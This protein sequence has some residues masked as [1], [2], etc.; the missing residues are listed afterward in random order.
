MPRRGWR[1]RDDERGAVLD[2][3]RCHLW[4]RSRQR[5]PNP[6]R[7]TAGRDARLDGPPDGCRDQLACALCLGL[8][9]ARSGGPEMIA[10]TQRRLAITG[11]LVATG[12][13]IA[14]NAHLITVA[15][16]SQ[17]DCT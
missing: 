3:R 5:K 15:I 14:A 8:A 13:F 10:V 1:R 16:R 9:P 4:P 7:W 2:R 11:A 17:P 6:T 12:V